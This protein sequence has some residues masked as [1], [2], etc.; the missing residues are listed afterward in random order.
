MDSRPGATHNGARPRKRIRGPDTDE[1]IGTTSK[2]ARQTKAC[3][4]C[5]KVKVKC[6]DPPDHDSRSS[7]TRCRR[8]G[9][10]CLREKISWISEDDDGWQTQLTLTKLERA[11]EDVL[12]KLQMPALDLYVTPAIVRS[13]HAPRETRPNSEEWD[14]GA[15]EVSPDPLN[16]LMEAT[17]LNGIRSQLRSVKLRRKGG[18]RRRDHDLI[19]ENLLSQEEAEELLEVFKKTQ[20]R[21]LF[22]ASIPEDATVDSIRASSTVLFT[23][24]MLVTALHISGKEKIHETCHG[25]FMGLVSS[26]MFDRFHTLDDIRGL[27]IAA[28]WQP[29]LSWKISGLSIRMATELNLHQAFYEAFN[30]PSAPAEE[31]QDNL[32]KAR[33]WYLLYVLDHQSSVNYGRPSIMSEMRP[34]KEHELLLKSEDCL[35]S[36][37]E[38]L[39]QVTGLVVLSRAFDFFGLESKRVVPGDDIAVMNLVRCSDDI[40]AWRDRQDALIGDNTGSAMRDADLQHTFSNLVLSAIVLRGRPLGKLA[41]LPNSLRPFAFQAVEAAHSILQQ[42]LEPEYREEI[43]GLPL[44][45]HSMIAFAIVFLMKMAQ[46]WHLIGITIDPTQR[47]LPLIERTIQMLRECNAGANHIVVAMASG[48]ERMLKQLRRSHNPRDTHRSE[49]DMRA[50]SDANIVGE[51]FRSLNGYESNVAQVSLDGAYPINHTSPETTS[52]QNLYA[53]WG[54]QDDDL[55]SVGMGFDLLDSSGQGLAAT[56]FPFDLSNWRC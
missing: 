37:R 7:C 49:R 3:A 12:E 50:Q 38:L 47:T 56:D 51:P 23:A 40:K 41:E 19:S 34:I 31:R 17:Q 30:D 33:L 39:S 35:R 14:E 4:G 15:R 28:F 18:M 55:W 27:C 1:D 10:Q 20:S 16:S 36:D 42:F 53:S 46:R 2:Q 9:L 8:L 6:T 29:Y 22:S 13:R 32:E 25:V 48:F 43:I 24:I 45:R 26:V 54:F 5:R 52:S 21:H 44:Y 11:L